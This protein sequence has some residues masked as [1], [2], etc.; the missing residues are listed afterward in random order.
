MF[1]RILLTICMGLFV[2]PVSAA[3]FSADAIQMRGA[4]LSHARM[5]W[6][7]GRVRFEYIDKGVPMVQIFDTVN[8]RVVW[9]DTEKKVYLEQELPAA[10]PL[11]L[12]QSGKL[13]ETSK[14]GKGLNPCQQLENAECYRLKEVVM[15]DRKTVKWL[16]TIKEDGRDYHV[17][18]W[19][20]TRQGIPVRQENPDGSILDAH[21]LDNQEYDGRPVR[22]VDMVA[23]MPDGRSVHGIQWYDNELDI[24][25][26]QQADS[27]IVDELRN[28]KV[29]KVS[30]SLF[31]IPDGYKSIG[32]R[33]TE[34]ATGSA[35]TLETV[36]E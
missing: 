23:I 35:H 5:Y 11:S 4:D 14:S 18:Q 28:I 26:R 17:F 20:D 2:W 32:S 3:S 7:D 30:D 29:E 16:I 36:T 10:S 27:G 13:G 8:N 9:L 25:V 21:I 24:I 12:A 1:A 6:S 22:K 19:L 33:K 31:V 34:S 15:N